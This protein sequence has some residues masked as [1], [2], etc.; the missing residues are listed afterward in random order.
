MPCRPMENPR[1]RDSWLG[2][3]LALFELS[4]RGASEDAYTAR[5]GILVA[6]TAIN[7][8]MRDRLTLVTAVGCDG[9]VRLTVAPLGRH[10]KPR[11]RGR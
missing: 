3:F 10:F 7:L 2:D 8:L 6:A 1:Q 5:A 11:S 4:W 9:S